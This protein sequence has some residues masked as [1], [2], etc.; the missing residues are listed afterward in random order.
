MTTFE[1]KYVVVN[2][3]TSEVVRWETLPNNCNRM[4]TV[5][6]KGIF[7]A[8]EHENSLETDINKIKLTKSSSSIFKKGRFSMNR[9]KDKSLKEKKLAKIKS[10]FFHK[11]PQ[12][13]VRFADES[14]IIKDDDQYFNQLSSS[15]AVKKLQKKEDNESVEDKKE[16]SENSFLKDKFT[17]LRK[18]R[19]SIANIKAMHYEN[20]KLINDYDTSSEDENGNKKPASFIRNIK[21]LEQ[22][23]LSCQDLTKLQNLEN[24]YD[25]NTENEDSIDHHNLAATQPQE[26]SNYELTDKDMIIMV[27]MVLPY[28]VVKQDG[29]LALK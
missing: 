25:Q 19:K 12:N 13:S 23:V 18:K 16:S 9:G 24:P 29:K 1:Y 27:S 6:K 14:D 5:K 20:N 15:K 8:I 17:L 7:S 10:Q 2:S 3:E 4:M 11:T 26:I 22:R 28:I 21:D